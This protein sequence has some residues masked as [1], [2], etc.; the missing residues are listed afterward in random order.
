MFLDYNGIK[1]EI[2]NRKI[3]ESSQNTGKLNNMFLN[4]I[5]VK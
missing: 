5:W 1:L 2:S 3:T 4:Y